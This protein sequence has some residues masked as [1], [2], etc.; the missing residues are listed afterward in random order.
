[1]KKILLMLIVGGIG[2]VLL[3]NFVLPV[4]VQAD[5]FGSASFFK[6]FVKSQVETLVKETERVVTIEPDFWKKVVP[7][8][9]KSVVFVQYF[10]SA[11]TLLSQSNGIILTNDG[12]IVIPLS[13]IPRSFSVVQVFSGDRIIKGTLAVSDPA[14]SLALIKLDASSLPILDFADLN[15][16]V[17]GQN[18]LVV[19]KKIAVNKVSTFTHS[20]LI[21]EIDNQ[22]LFLDLERGQQRGQISGAAAVDSGGKLAGMIQISGQGHVFVMP[23]SFLRT[24]LEKY[25]SS[26]S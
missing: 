25:L 14:S 3:G 10:S 17:L 21:S 20:S 18:V 13:S 23:H 1:M 4:L 11:G 12:L 26:K 24:L 16:L 7:G 2:G 19:G 8:V 9:E 15:N 5:F 22:T 6:I